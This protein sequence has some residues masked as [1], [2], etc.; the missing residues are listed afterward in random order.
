LDLHA[1]M[2]AA[3]ANTV[4]LWFTDTYVSVS[5]FIGECKALEEIPVASMATAW[6]HP[7]TGETYL[8]VINEALYFGDWIGHSLISLNQPKDFGLQ[9]NNMLTYYDPTSSHSIF[10]PE[11]DLELPLQVR[12]VFSYLET[13][14]PTD[15]ELVSCQHVE[16]TSASPWDPDIASRDGSAQGMAEGTL[17]GCELSGAYGE[18]FALHG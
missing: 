15:N 9:V 18:H 16:L 6:D 2:S 1:N 7:L 13:R 14:K 8:L 17:L 12:S 10:L 3:G 4:S 5:P 11:S